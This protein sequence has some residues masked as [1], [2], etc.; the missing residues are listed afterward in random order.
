MIYFVQCKRRRIT[1]IVEFRYPR[2]LRPSSFEIDMVGKLVFGVNKLFP[3]DEGL[4]IMAPTAPA[5]D[6]A[7]TRSVM[8]KVL[9]KHSTTLPVTIES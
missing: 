3:W 4:K 6:T 7:L 1:H 9:L 5:E 2:T 8:D